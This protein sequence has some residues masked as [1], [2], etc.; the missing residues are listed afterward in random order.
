[1]DD[2][3]SKPISIQ[4]LAAALNRCRKES[5]HPVHMSHLET[6]ELEIPPT[7][8][9]KDPA[10]ELDLGALEQLQKTLGKRSREMLPML[11]E[12]YF[13]DAAQLLE[14]AQ[15][16]INEGKNDDLRRAAHTL[17]S[18][19]ASFGAMQL[20]RL[21]QELENQAKSGLLENAPGQMSKIREQY[22]QTS[23]ALRHWADGE[24]KKLAL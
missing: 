21:C 1:M 16:A 24:S 11:M 6:V 9:V 7:P 12:T 5:P 4:E 17:K 13:Q 8:Q 14:T 18:N 20:S 22:E 23:R 19:S 3:V 15:V 10:G 2:Y